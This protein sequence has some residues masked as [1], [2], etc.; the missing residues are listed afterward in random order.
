MHER[1]SFSNSFS[2]QQRLAFRHYHRLQHPRLRFPNYLRLLI[3]D[4]SHADLRATL[5]HRVW[6]RTK[7][8]LGRGIWRVGDRGSVGVGSVPSYRK[9][10]NVAYFLL[11]VFAEGFFNPTLGGNE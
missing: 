2:D 10:T 3:H 7:L 11:V 1:L 4:S 5:E 9:D 6:L 8:K